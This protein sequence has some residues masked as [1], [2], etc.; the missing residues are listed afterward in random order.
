MS[1]P[2]PARVLA[3]AAWAPDAQSACSSSVDHALPDADRARSARCAPT[4]MR[5]PPRR[6]S[7]RAAR[8]GSV[9]T[10]VRRTSSRRPASRTR[11]RRNRTRCARSCPRAK[12][13]Q[14]RGPARR[15]ERT[16]PV[17]LHVRHGDVEQA[18][19]DAAGRTAWATPA[20]PWAA[21]RNT[22]VD[23]RRK[24]DMGPPGESG[25]RASD[26]GAVGA[27]PTSGRMPNAESG[28]THRTRWIDLYR[29][30]M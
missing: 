15:R 13:A 22:G 25:R 16:I 20:T 3:S 21:A 4:R 10:A 17:L 27:I 14:D 29:R 23:E 30:P 18:E 28:C 26:A 9:R 24:R 7:R 6:P 5:P 19:D 2:S 11:R 1:R 8:R 12:I